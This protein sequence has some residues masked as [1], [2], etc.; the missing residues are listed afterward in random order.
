MRVRSRGLRIRLMTSDERN[1]M[2]QW[3]AQWQTA[4]PLLEQK[5]WDRLRAMTDDDA[6][7]DALLVWD[8]WRADWPS[9]E[10][11]GLLLF[12]EVLGRAR[13]RP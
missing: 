13:R 3:L 1:R 2:R 11:R 9:D 8:F 6:R 5:R 7:R 10:G 12:E 4:G